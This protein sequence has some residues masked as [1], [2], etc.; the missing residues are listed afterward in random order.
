MDKYRTTIDVYR[1]RS[2][3]WSR[4]LQEIREHY[5]RD[6][7]GAY[8]A[9][10]ELDKLVL[11][12]EQYFVQ[13]FHDRQTVVEH[14]TTPARLFSPASV[15]NVTVFDKGQSLKSYELAKIETV[16]NEISAHFNLV[17]SKLRQRRREERDHQDKQ[18]EQQRT[19]EA[20]QRNHDRQHEL[21]LKDKEIELRRLELELKKTEI[22][23]EAQRAEQQRGHELNLTR[24][25]GEVEQMRLKTVQPVE[26]QK[27]LA[28]ITLAAWEKQEHDPTYRATYAKAR[29][30]LA[31]AQTSVSRLVADRDVDGHE[32]TP[33]TRAK[34]EEEALTWVLRVVERL[35]TRVTE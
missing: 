34:A 23:L 14:Y 4:H 21:A 26:L 16:R 33:E 31:E 29:E 5:Y 8:D 19:H 17:E 24:L 30:I 32:L 13:K 10:V 6:E 27:T 18:Q 1:V 15:T 7:R 11:E 25:K 3:I 22:E 35:M 9:F 2:D 28:A 20:E 12:V